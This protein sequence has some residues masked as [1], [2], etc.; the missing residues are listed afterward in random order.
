MDHSLLVVELV[1]GLIHGVH[2]QSVFRVGA[3]HKH[4]GP[5][6]DTEGEEEEGADVAKMGELAHDN[7]YGEGTDTLDKRPQT[8]CDPEDMMHDGGPGPRAHVYTQQEDALP[9]LVPVHRAHAQIRRRSKRQPL[10]RQQT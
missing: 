8:G 5:E 3:P 9:D 1:L 2:V 7:P 6:R 10:G 4:A